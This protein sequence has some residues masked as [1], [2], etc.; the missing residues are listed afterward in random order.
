MSLSQEIKQYYFERLGELPP[1]KR[2]HYA[3]RLAAWEGEARAYSVLRQLRSYIISADKP[4]QAVISEILRQQ[5]HKGINA[6]ET[7]KPFFD[8]Y[9]GLYGIHS[10]LFRV[11]HLK[12]VYGI[13]ALPALFDEIGK[14]RLDEL[15]DKLMTDKAALKTLSTYAVNYLYLYK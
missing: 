10:A 4:L 7:R 5:P 14:Q 15:A 11:R 1:D 9:S 6:Y 12:A 8:K 2:F 3:S 13:D